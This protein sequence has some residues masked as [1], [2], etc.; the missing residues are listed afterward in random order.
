MK[1]KNHEIIIFYEFF[2]W[3]LNA[4]IGHHCQII[5]FWHNMN[6][7]NPRAFLLSNLA[8]KKIKILNVKLDEII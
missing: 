7:K 4:M 2:S 8:S 3:T 5:L 6:Q 1:I